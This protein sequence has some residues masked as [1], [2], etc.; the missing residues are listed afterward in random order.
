MGELVHIALGSNLGDRDAALA[1]ARLALRAL[2]G[3]RLLAETPVEETPPFGPAGQG[4]YLNQMVAVET[5][6]TPHQLLDALHGIER[7][8]G[9]TRRVRWGPRTLDLD[10]VTFGDRTID[11]ERLTVP[12]PGLADRAFWQRELAHLAVRRDETH[13]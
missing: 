7:A 1:A 6:L 13:A 12:H 5:T 11:D 8:A 10:I 4:D 3:V 9:R 2:A